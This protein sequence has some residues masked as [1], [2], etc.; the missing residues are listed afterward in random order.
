MAC[1]QQTAVSFSVY[2]ALTYIPVEDS[3]DRVWPVFSSICFVLFFDFSAVG[4]PKP[5]PQVT[6]CASA[7]D[8]RQHQSPT[9]APEADAH[10]R[11]QSC[12]C[13]ASRGRSGRL[14]R[15]EA[16]PAQVGRDF[17]LRECAR[18]RH[19]CG[20]GLSPAPRPHRDGRLRRR[21]GRHCRRR[22]PA[23]LLC[24]RRRAVGREALVLPLL[25]RAS[26]AARRSTDRDPV[27]DERR[28]GLLVH[29]LRLGLGRLSPAH[30]RRGRAR[31]RTATLR[32]AVRRA[33]RPPRSRRRIKGVGRAWLT[34]RLLCEQASA[35]LRRGC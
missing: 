29:L 4:R 13:G 24:G 22:R 28:R 18:L 3:A 30:D 20:D 6:L 9:N 16:D 34:V 31:R 11:G 15:W 25:P 10:D 27:H 1:W 19:L 21:G 2:E 35:S 23:A 5:G 12:C 26:D 8:L 17:W 7:S 33:R 14:A 32:R